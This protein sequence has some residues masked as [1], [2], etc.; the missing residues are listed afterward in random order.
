MLNMS[1]WSKLTAQSVEEKLN[2]LNQQIGSTFSLD[3]RNTENPSVVEYGVFCNGRLF[4]A[5]SL[6]NIDSYID[7]IYV[8]VGL[9]KNSNNVNSNNVQKV[10][11][12]VENPSAYPLSNGGY[13][14]NP[15]Q[16]FLKSRQT[17]EHC[18]KFYLMGKKK[19]VDPD[20][21][22]DGLKY[23]VE[24]IELTDTYMVFNV[25]YVMLAPNQT[26]WGKTYYYSGL[27]IQLNPAMSLEEFAYEITKECDKSYINEALLTAPNRFASRYI[28]TVTPDLPD[29]LGFYEGAVTTHSYAK[30]IS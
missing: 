9:P 16:T 15:V 13:K 14:N 17:K 4:K 11:I 19:A 5:G 30:V 26:S 24:V 3:K 8:G 20:W 1:G 7:G 28:L 10:S 6:S 29:K 21:S 18:N 22:D 12:S 27:T 25:K 23:C 2:Y